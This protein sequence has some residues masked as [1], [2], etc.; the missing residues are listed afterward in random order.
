MIIYLEVRQVTAT[1]VKQ[2]GGQEQVER[3]SRQAVDWLTVD[4]QRTSHMVHRDTNLRVAQTS[5]NINSV[6]KIPTTESLNIF[7]NIF[8]SSMIKNSIF[9]M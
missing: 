3:I 1:Q 6:I 8:N 4:T 7:F 9:A 2:L 5:H